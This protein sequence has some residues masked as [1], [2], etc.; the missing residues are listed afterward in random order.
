MPARYL[1]IKKE[2]S[3][4]MP[5]FMP[6]WMSDWMRKVLLSRISAAMDGVLIMISNAATRPGLSTR[7]IS[8]C[9]MT[10]CNTVES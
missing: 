2:S 8:N 10:A 1:S 9:E 4:T 7:G 3:V 6:V 5:N